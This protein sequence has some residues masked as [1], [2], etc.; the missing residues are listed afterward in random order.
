L[1]YLVPDYQEDEESV[2]SADTLASFK[3]EGEKALKYV[4]I[5]RTRP[6]SCD[7]FVNLFTLTSKMPEKLEHKSICER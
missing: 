5:K 6:K 2:Y 7:R 1:W 4:K 3:I